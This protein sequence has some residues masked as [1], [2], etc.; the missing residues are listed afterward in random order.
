MDRKSVERLHH[1]NMQAWLPTLGIAS[2][3]FATL[4]DKAVRTIQDPVPRQNSIRM[5]LARV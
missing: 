1:A 5:E 2:Y 3:P 4:L